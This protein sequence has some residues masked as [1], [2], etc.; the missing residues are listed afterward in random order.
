ML[1]GSII[2]NLSDET[3]ILETLTSLDDLVL[4]ARI[5]EAAAAS[6]EPL[7]SLASAAVGS[8][9]GHADDSAW[10]SL[11]AAMSRADDPGT[12]CLKYILT[13]VMALPA[14]SVH[15]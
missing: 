8:F 2:A 10:V 13:T 6:G 14:A 5:R 11:M 1:L 12:A 7:G 9:V 3:R 4:L 15:H